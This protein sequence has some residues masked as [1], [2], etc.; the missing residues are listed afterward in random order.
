M[1]KIFLLKILFLVKTLFFVKITQTH[2]NSQVFFQHK[3]RFLFKT[4]SN[5]S[6][7]TA[8]RA[9]TH[10]RRLQDSK[11]HSHPTKNRGLTLSSRLIGSRTVL[12]ENDVF[13][14]RRAAEDAGA[15]C[16]RPKRLDRK[17]RF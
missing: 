1:F 11:P 7:P 9:H 15:W 8:A 10:R 6:P 13:D 4:S 12:I 2:T 16:G 14:S 17:R 5:R 3:Q